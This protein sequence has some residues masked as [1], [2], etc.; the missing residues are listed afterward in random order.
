MICAFYQNSNVYS[1]ITDTLS[2]G[3]M[4]LRSTGNSYDG[5]FKG[6]IKHYIDYEIPRDFCPGKGNGKLN[7][8]GQRKFLI[9]VH[10]GA[11]ITVALTS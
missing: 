6:I 1:V 3:K 11:Q 9:L 2:W 5:I 4:I 10:P 8:T 7:Q